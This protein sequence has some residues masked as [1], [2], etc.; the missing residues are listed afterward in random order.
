M[1]CDR[2]D[3]SRSVGREKI[4]LSVIFK[5]LKFLDFYLEGL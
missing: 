4:V 3:Q 2:S 5:T 1:V